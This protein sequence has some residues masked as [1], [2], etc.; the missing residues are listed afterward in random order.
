MAARGGSIVTVSS[1]AGAAAMPR[2]VAYSAAKAGVIGLTRTLAVEWAPR[3]IRV[4]CVA[5]GFV[6]RDDDPFRDRPDE[7]ERIL[8]A[9]PMGRRGTPR[10]GALAVLFLASPAASFVTG[11]VLAVDGGWLAA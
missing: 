5:P 4:N 6:V 1:I 3:D 7:L 9:T 11:A 2:A 10:E 8:A